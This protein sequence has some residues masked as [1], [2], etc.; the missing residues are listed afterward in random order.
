MGATRQRG[1]E[2][3]RLLRLRK[4]LP[5]GARAVLGCIQAGERGRGPSPSFLSARRQ[6]CPSSAPEGGS[7]VP[8]PC[9][10]GFALA[11][12]PPLRGPA[13]SPCLWAAL[14]WKCLTCRG[15]VASS[16]GGEQ[17]EAS[18]SG[19]WDEVCEENL[20][21]LY[22]RM[23]LGAWSACR[24]TEG[25]VLRNEG[26]KKWGAHGNRQVEAGA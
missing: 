14:S 4:P 24:R 16:W 17:R 3:Q 18:W 8:V 15:A 12:L 26:L 7:Q 20:S 5:G 6:Q 2:G 9:K 1:A 13:A 23:K 25:A 22:L 19:G 10:R 11:V 21:G